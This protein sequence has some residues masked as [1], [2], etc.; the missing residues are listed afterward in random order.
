M[1]AIWN[2]TVIAESDATI[3][4]EGNQYF[5]P[6][7]LKTW[8]R[9]STSSRGRRRGVSTIPRLQA[10]SRCRGTRP[11]VSLRAAIDPSMLTARTGTAGVQYRTQENML[12]Q[13]VDTATLDRLP[14][15]TQFD[16]GWSFTPNQ[17][18]GENWTR[19]TN[20]VSGTQS[21]NYQKVT[22]ATGSYHWAGGVRTRMGAP[23][24][25]QHP[26]Q[27]VLRRGR[28]VQLVPGDLRSPDAHADQ[29]G[30]GVEPD[31]HQVHRRQ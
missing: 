28:P 4:V 3:E 1:K 10:V 29:H 15:S 27:R 30:Q 23:F 26:F 16:Y 2:N 31:Q 8:S 14:T 9:S 18:T 6:E 19:S 20:L 22:T 21:S 17:V 5:P 11:T 13:W 7:A 25:L 12:Y 24:G